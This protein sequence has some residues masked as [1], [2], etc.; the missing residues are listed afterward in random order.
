MHTNEARTLLQAY[1]TLR[2]G[3]KT[4]SV[5]DL[6]VTLEWTGCWKETDSKVLL[7]ASATCAGIRH[8][9]LQSHRHCT[10]RNSGFR[11][12]YMY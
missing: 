7:C 1:Q 2:K 5:Y 3:N 10:S 12:C 8:T 11:T 9:Y 6:T 4:F